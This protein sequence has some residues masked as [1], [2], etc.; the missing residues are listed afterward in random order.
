MAHNRTKQPDE[1]T[2]LDCCR[3]FQDTITHI[4]KDHRDYVPVFCYSAAHGRSDMDNKYKYRTTLAALNKLNP[5]GVW[6]LTTV[7]HGLQKYLKDAG[8]SLDF[9]ACRKSASNLMSLLQECRRSKFNVKTGIRTPT[10]YQSV[11]NPLTLDP[12]KKGHLAIVPYEGDTSGP[13]GVSRD[14][15]ACSSGDSRNMLAPPKLK[16]KRTLKFQVSEVSDAPTELYVDPEDMGT[17]DNDLDD[18]A[19]YLWDDV[20]N[21]GKLIL[22]SGRSKVCST[23]VKDTSGFMRCIWYDDGTGHRREWVSEVPVLSYKDHDAELAEVALKKPAAAMKK[24]AAAKAG[25]KSSLKKLL[26]SREYHNALVGAKKCG[27]L[28]DKAKD[29]AR[30]AAQKAV[31]GM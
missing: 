17:A 29:L 30:A 6:K 24:P 15:A 13:N 3:V 25:P 11:I 21:K 1:I 14:R 23:V 22:P 26:Y 7:E 19:T 12:V 10:W 16:R 8:L 20:L 31:E 9:A 2:S 18:D 4:A 27:H 28:H 5:V